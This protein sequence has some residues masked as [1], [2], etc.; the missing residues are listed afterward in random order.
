MSFGL[1]RGRTLAFDGYGLARADLPPWRDDGDPAANRIDPRTWFADPGR[2]FE[3]EIGSGKGTFLVQQAPRAPMT[4]FLGIEWARE[5]FAY[6][7]DRV[8]RHA[9]ANV[10]MLHADATEFIR[11]RLPDGIVDVIHLY[12]S[13]PWPKARH[14]KRRVVQDATLV[15]FHRVLT[16][17][18][19]LRI[20]TDHPDLRAW[21]EAHA[22]RHAD[23]FERLPFTPAAT[24][25]VDEAVAGAADDQDDRDADDDT[26]TRRDAPI[27]PRAD[28]AAA[29]ELVGTNYERKFREA[30]RPTFFAMTLR[31]RG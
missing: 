29:G 20:V 15:E 25:A 28:S 4:N 18:G 14:H 22:S 16:A 9:L 21:Y 7:A 13:D 5:F 12:F 2:R 1:A 31:R 8:R 23:R 30:G 24:T 19:E 10:R 17:G 6:A 27:A 11:W 26:G 3:L